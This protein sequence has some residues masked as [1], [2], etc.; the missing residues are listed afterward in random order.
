LKN[1]VT[2]GLEQGPGDH[3]DVVDAQVG[4][5]RERLALGVVERVRHDD[6]HGPGAEAL[7]GEDALARMIASPVVSTSFSSI[8][9]SSILVTSGRSVSFETKRA[10]SSARAGTS[11]RSSCG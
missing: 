6:R 10:V 11:G 9:R 5:L 1:F 2:S 3:L 7:V 4:R 8:S